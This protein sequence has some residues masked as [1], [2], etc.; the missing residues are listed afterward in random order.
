MKNRSFMSPKVAVIELLAFSSAQK[1]W[2]GPGEKS[3]PQQWRNPHLGVIVAPASAMSTG[4][5]AAQKTGPPPSTM[6]EGMKV[7]LL[8]SP[9][10]AVY[11]G[12]TLVS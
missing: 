6:L 12:P 11:S 2:P 5:G 3:H 9:G 7:T 4:T 1:T 10:S 8:A